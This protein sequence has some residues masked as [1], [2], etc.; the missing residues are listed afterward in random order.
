MALHPYCIFNSLPVLR[1]GFFYQNKKR[2]SRDRCPYLLER[3]LT[4]LLCAP[5]VLNPHVAAIGPA[6]LLHALQDKHGVLATDVV[7]HPPEERPSEPTGYGAL[8][9]FA[10][11]PFLFVL[12]SG[13]V[14]FAWGEIYSLFPTHV[15]CELPQPPPRGDHLSGV[16]AMLVVAGG[17]ITAAHASMCELLHTRK[18]ASE[19]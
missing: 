11:D 7:R 15:S 19:A 17:D 5:T 3:P 14:F 4:G 9:H 18:H 1:T 2:T 13:L 16:P 6:Q 8:L 12:L 10:S